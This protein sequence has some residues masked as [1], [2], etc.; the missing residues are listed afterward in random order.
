MRTYSEIILSFIE[1]VLI[2]LCSSP[3]KLH[4]LTE[5]NNSKEEIYQKELLSFIVREGVTI[6][7]VGLD[8]RDYLLYALYSKF[9]VKFVH[10]HACPPT[11]MH[12]F[13]FFWNWPN[14]IE[15]SIIIFKR[16]FNFM[17]CLLLNV[18]ITDHSIYI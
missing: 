2:F 14:V 16:I 15:T 7:L 3:G 10:Y 18:H 9:Q 8:L 5:N 6:A 17:L 12:S 13:F 1:S 4:S 11:N